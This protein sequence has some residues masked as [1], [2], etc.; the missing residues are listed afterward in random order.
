MQG[1]CIV[2]AVAVFIDYL[3]QLTWF[4]AALS[5]DARRV[6]ASRADFVCCVKVADDAVP[7]NRFWQFVNNGEYVKNFLKAYYAPFI[8]QPLVKVRRARRVSGLS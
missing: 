6:T 8:M 7:D 4:M 3:L 2:A 5:L 1:F